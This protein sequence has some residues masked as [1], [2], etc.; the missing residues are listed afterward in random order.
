[1]FWYEQISAYAD[2]GMP[3]S[4][5]GI[6]RRIIR[7]PEPSRR[8]MQYRLQACSRSA[9]GSARTGAFFHLS[10]IKVDLVMMNVFRGM[11]LDF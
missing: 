4:N 2:S 10:L 5:E 7:L 9:R 1:M 6:E 3:G 8:L 11:S